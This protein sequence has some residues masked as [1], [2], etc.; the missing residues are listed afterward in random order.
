MTG[1]L[2]RSFVAPFAKVLMFY[3]IVKH[4]CEKGP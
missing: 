3:S 1:L 4:D 2:M